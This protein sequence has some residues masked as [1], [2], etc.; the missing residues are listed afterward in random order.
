MSQD[1]KHRGVRGALDVVEDVAGA[2]LEQ[3]SAAVSG[4]SGSV[5]VRNAALADLYAI[6]AAQIARARA[7]V[8]QVR[9][10]ADKLAAAH[11]VGLQ[12]LYAAWSRSEVK[13]DAAPAPA[14]L[15]PRR[16]TMIDDLTKAP[17]EH[18]DATYLHQQLAA[19]AEARTLFEAYLNEGDDIQLRSHALTML[20]GVETHARTA[21]ALLNLLVR[22]KS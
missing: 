8:P 12:L 18:L 13:D 17:I 22:P 11:R 1:D 5:L 2:V 20:P 16:Q 9:A 15:D 14:A 4:R 19:H 10:F 3:A 7:K 21:N 6:E